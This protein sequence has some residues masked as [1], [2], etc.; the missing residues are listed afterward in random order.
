[1]RVL[2]TSPEQLYITR[3]KGYWTE[4]ELELLWGVNPSSL[5]IGIKV[6]TKLT[7][8]IFKTQGG[9]LRNTRADMAQS[10]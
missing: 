2:R 7:A 9:D 8:S 10:V 4:T 3:A 1:M 5:D 6:S